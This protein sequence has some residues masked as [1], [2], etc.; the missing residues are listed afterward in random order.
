MQPVVDYIYQQ[1]FLD[2]TCR[3]NEYNPYD[4]AK[5]REEIDE[6]GESEIQ[7]LASVL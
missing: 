3:L 1:C 4:L 2:S 5:Y 6:K 7:L